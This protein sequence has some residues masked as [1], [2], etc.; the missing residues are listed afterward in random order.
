MRLVYHNGTD[1]VAAK[2]E[3]NRD[4]K[5]VVGFIEQAAANLK[6]IPVCKERCTAGAWVTQGLGFRGQGSGF[7][8]QV[9]DRIHD[10]WFV[11]HGS[12]LGFSAQG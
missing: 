12:W 3:G 5:A 10:S 9:Q 1:L 8:V 11:V 4:Y 6:Q 7:R 2:Y